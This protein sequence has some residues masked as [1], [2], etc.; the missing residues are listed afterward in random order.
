MDA[1]LFVK[2]QLGILLSVK[3]TTFSVAIAVAETLSRRYAE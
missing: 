1:A 2:S 3:R